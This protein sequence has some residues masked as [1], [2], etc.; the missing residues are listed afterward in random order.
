ML[1]GSVITCGVVGRDVCPALVGAALV[2]PAEL[3]AA[4]VGAAELGVA[5]VGAGLVGAEVTATVLAGRGDPAERC[6]VPG[7]RVRA[8][9]D[10][11]LDGN[12]PEGSI[13]E[14]SIEASGLGS[15]DVDAAPGMAGP[16][17]AASVGAAGPSPTRITVAA[18]RPI[19]AP[20]GRASIVEGIDEGIGAI[21]VGGATRA[22]LERFVFAAF[23]AFTAEAEVRCD[24]SVAVAITLMQPNVP[25]AVATNNRLRTFAIAVELTATV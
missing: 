20:S 4:L 8:T 24:P 7:V 3:G 11:E 6:G 5:G 14:G 10:G 17:L 9:G 15:G 2:G 12:E 13:V 19:G 16:A 23:D 21:V 22:P 18:A 1:V 25:A